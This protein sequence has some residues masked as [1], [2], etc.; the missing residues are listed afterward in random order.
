M[1]DTQIENYARRVEKHCDKAKTSTLL[2]EDHA[3]KGEFQ[4]GTKHAKEAIIELE[5][6]IAELKTI[7]P[8]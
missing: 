1:R 2:C 5:N 8:E 6:A 3:S 7:L 4:I